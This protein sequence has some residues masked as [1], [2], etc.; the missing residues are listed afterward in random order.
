MKKL[1]SFFLW[2]AISLS[3][4]ISVAATAPT[5]PEELA[6]LEL[7]NVV[8]SFDPDYAVSEVNDN[9][10]EIQV[11][12]GNAYI[13]IFVTELSEYSDTTRELT[14]MFQ[15]SLM[16]ADARNGEEVT[17][18]KIERTVLGKLVTFAEFTTSDGIFWSVGTFFDDGYAYSVTLGTVDTSEETMQL[19]EDFISM[20]SVAKEK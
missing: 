17:S 11:K 1:V 3:F 19:Y 16:E 9:T 2:I 20:I 5:E 7:G 4:V 18:E 15:Q 10:T 12:K 14:A 8:F 13:S 6:T